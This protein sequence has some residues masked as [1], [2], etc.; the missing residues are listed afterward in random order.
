LVRLTYLATIVSVTIGLV[1]LTPVRG[2]ARESGASHASEV[3]AKLV[4]YLATHDVPAAPDLRAIEKSPEPSLMDIASD[5]HL[6]AL[7]RARA[8]SALRL[9]PSPS[10]QAFLGQV[11][12]SKA[13]ATD[14]GQRLIVR[15]A[16]V[17]LGWMPSAEA[18]AKLALLFE[19]EDAEVRLDAAIAL[20][21]TRLAEAAVFLRQQLAAESAPR[22]RDQ[23]ERQLRVLSEV[24]AEPDK[25]PA[26]NRQE[27]MRSGW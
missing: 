3:R 20:G 24:Y 25:A 4:A 7:T 21:L 5:D 16:A 23:I 27:P 14:A 12:Q 1:S 8:I 10:V 13:K 22:V 15:R 9:L 19:N 18:P 17:A 26:P 6:E 11:V 2:L